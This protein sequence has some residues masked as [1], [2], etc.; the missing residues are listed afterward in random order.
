[1]LFFPEI[2]QL[3]TQYKYVGYLWLHFLKCWN[4]ILLLEVNQTS[5]QLCGNRGRFV[6]A[7][8][9]KNCK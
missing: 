4:E 7:G 1:M 2:Y 9:D 8:F 6:L 5:S 3:Y